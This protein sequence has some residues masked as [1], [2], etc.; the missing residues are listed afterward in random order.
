MSPVSLSVADVLVQSVCSGHVDSSFC[1]SLTHDSAQSDESYTATQ[2]P[3]AGDNRGTE[4][5]AHDCIL[6]FSQTP[7][8]PS[9]PIPKLGISPFCAAR[10]LITELLPLL[11]P[12][13]CGQIN[14]GNEENIGSID[15]E[16]STDM[17]NLFKLLCEH[18]DDEA[19]TLHMSQAFWDTEE[20]V[21]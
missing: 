5:N 10:P 1:H 21:E 14:I 20:Q 16:A 7:S 12:N 6:P 19:E 11:S 18:Q 17:D 8:T 13:S 4:G 9:T 15:S 2:L 3:E